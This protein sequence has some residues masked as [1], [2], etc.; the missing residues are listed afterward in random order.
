MLR[1]NIPLYNENRSAMTPALMSLSTKTLESFKQE[2]L[3]RR[4][5]LARDLQA[6]TAEL[7]DDEPFYADSVDQA[8]ADAD[9]TVA[10]QMRNRDRGT[11]LQ[12][13]HALRRIDAGTFGIC[14]ECGESIAVARMR[15]N[16]AT[17]LCIDCQAEL[18]SEQ[19]RYPGRA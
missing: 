5:N 16:P 17:T 19:N 4:Q 2:L 9:K 1:V 3:V 13:D 10:V 7:I 15:A 12:I 14:N 18:E 11:L 6:A 8:N